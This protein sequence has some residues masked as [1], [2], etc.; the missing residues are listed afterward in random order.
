MKYAILITLT[1]ALAGCP[2]VT[3][4]ESRVDVPTALELLNAHMQ[5]RATLRQQTDN[6]LADNKILI[7]GVKTRVEELARLKAEPVSSAGV[8]PR[9]AVL[10][11]AI[12][13]AEAEIQT[14]S[15]LIQN[16]MNLMNA[17]DNALTLLVGEAVRNFRD[18]GTLTVTFQPVEVGQ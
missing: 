6:W 15:E 16:N 3:T 11:A 1:A 13:E 4:T 8:N 9:I 12:A 17:E 18:G 5:R 14:N 7:D 10:E 2:M